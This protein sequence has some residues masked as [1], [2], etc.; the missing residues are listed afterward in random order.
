VALVAVLAAADEQP[1]FAGAVLLLAG[2]LLGYRALIGPPDQPR[3]H[4]RFPLLGLAVFVIG[5]VSAVVLSPALLTL[6]V[7]GLDAV[8][9]ADLAV[10]ERVVDRP[11]NNV[12]SL[13][14]LGGMLWAWLIGPRSIPDA[15]AAAAGSEPATRN[16]ARQSLRLI[17]TGTL[18][19]VVLA[20]AITAG[21]HDVT[22]HQPV[23]AGDPGTSQTVAGVS[24]AVTDVRVVDTLRTPTN[25]TVTPEENTSVFVLVKYQT[26]NE[27]DR[28][29]QPPY[30]PSLTVVPAGNET[31]RNRRRIYLEDESANDFVGGE[32][33]QAIID[34]ETVPLYTDETSSIVGLL[35][36][37]VDN[38]S[39]TL[40]P[41][42]H[43]SR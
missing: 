40:S 37:H 8:A 9:G 24:V 39:R 22:V 26:I 21:L 16:R 23:A 25:Q 15:P 7:R 19:V 38:R 34:N 28:S 29:V 27:R 4:S 2:S 35:S 11:I 13:I 14:V 42:E 3:H 43:R 33:E 41:R 36:G 1:A 5:L 30:Y 20:L 17:A 18:L 31:P 6:T 10:A 32:H 12:L